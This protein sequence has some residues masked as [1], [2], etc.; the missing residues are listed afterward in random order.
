MYLTVQYHLAFLVYSMSILAT[1]SSVIDVIYDVYVVL[2]AFTLR[3][4]D[5]DAQ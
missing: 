2:P 4:F 1:C 5:S 3:C